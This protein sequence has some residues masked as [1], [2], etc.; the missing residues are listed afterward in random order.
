MVIDLFYFFEVSPYRKEDFSI[1]Q[2]RLGLDDEVIL[3]HVECRWLTLIPAVCRVIAQW[4]P[5][6]EYF[7]LT[8]PKISRE[9]STQRELMANEKYKR[10]CAKLKGSQHNV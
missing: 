6:K 5:L 3:K 7:L 8:L 4:T 10:I 9:T 2:T 1:V